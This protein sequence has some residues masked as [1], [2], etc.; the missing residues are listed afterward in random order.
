[1][2]L[3]G[4]CVG[5]TVIALRKWSQDALRVCGV[6][7]ESGYGLE[8]R[9]A[10]AGADCVLGEWRCQRQGLGEVEINNIQDGYG[11]GRMHGYEICYIV[12]GISVDGHGWRWK[13]WMFYCGWTM[14]S[15]VPRVRRCG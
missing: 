6:Q 12:I 9:N 4:L 13:Q 8:D 15:A 1:M 14:Q 10:D 2:A 5:L 3:T 11:V 7:M